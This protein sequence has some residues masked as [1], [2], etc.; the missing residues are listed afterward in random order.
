MLGISGDELVELLLPL[1][2]I[3]DAGVYWGV[4]VKYHVEDDLKMSPTL[5]YPSL[6]VTE[7]GMENYTELWAFT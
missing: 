2:G 1:Y 3:F 6:H 5:A 4:T 7:S